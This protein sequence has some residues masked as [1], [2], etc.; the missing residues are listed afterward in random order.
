MTT[1]EALIE[2]QAA[3]VEAL[4]KRIAGLDAMLTQGAQE[5]NQLIA[6]ALHAGGKLE[7]MKEALGLQENK[8]E[9]AAN[10]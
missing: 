3:A 8:P 7:G 2:Q 4:K 10:G 1:L 9:E 5:R 6:D